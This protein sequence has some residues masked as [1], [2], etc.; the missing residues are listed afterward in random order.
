M[1]IDEKGWKKLVEDD[2]L[3]K[4]LKKLKIIKKQISRDYGDFTFL[5]SDN[6]KEIFTILRKAKNK[7]KY[8]DVILLIGTG[9][10]SLGSKA[11]LSLYF[12]NRVSFLEN[13]DPNSIKNYLKL[14]K[15]KKIGLLIISKS[16]ET[17]EVLSLFDVIINIFKK[18]INLE[19]T[20]IVIADKRESTLST[21]AEKYNIEVIAHDK[22]IGGRFSCFS[23]TGLLP[24]HL[25]GINAIKLKYYIDESFK[26]IL[27][28]DKF[29][30]N[31]SISILASLTKKKKFMGHVFLIYIDSFK[32]I[33]KWYKQ[34][35]TESL[36]KKKLG[37]HLITAS[38]AVDQHSQL[39]MWLDGP[40]NLIFTMV[41]AKYKRFDLTIK[42]SKG[43]LPNCLRGKNLGDILN[44][45]AEATAIELRKA[46]IPVRIIYLKNDGIESAIDL[47]TS[48]LLEVA[49]IGKLIGVD[50]F[51]QPAVE[52]VKI[53]TKNILNKYA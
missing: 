41:V 53:R 27:L 48:F 15:K 44:T 33:G 47:M 21:I 5:R 39:Q 25:G 18:Q 31:N 36:G 22:K 19:K 51:N 2:F 24:I 38:G 11:L 34:L 8:V 10:S 28:F 43:I 13:L 49:L 1:L 29:R 9:G 46:G 50:P 20:A 37:L 42:D 17:V 3:K 32:S 6:N 12:N 40:K 26:N 16:G 45:M 23:I 4:Y 52:K 35:W 30:S 14:N 7:F